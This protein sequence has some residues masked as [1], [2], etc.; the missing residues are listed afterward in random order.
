MVREFAGSLGY[1]GG[2]RV[3]L[4]L[5]ERYFWS[6]MQAD[7]YRWCAEQ[8]PNQAEKASFHHPPYLFPTH[9]QGG[10]FH[11]WQLDFAEQLIPHHPSGY[12]HLLICVDPMSKWLEVGKFTELTSGALVSWF[13]ENI[14]CRY[15]APV[16]CRTDNGKVFLGD[17]KLYL[18]DIG[19][20]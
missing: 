5:R 12:K 19:V 6:G 10:L 13:H 7:I 1:P 3:Y 4:Y 8:L 15:G 20:R 9:K 2:L 11:T 18:E 14:T 16:A 17:F